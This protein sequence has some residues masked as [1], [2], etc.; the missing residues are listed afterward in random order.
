MKNCDN[1]TVAEETVAYPQISKV[2]LEAC[3]FKQKVPHARSFA[4]IDRLKA[5]KQTICCNGHGCS[6]WSCCL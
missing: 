4:S 3:S 2:V 6:S 5:L 1:S